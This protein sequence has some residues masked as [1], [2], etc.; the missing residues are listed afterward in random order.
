MDQIK[1]F[2]DSDVFISALLSHKGASFEILN[3]ISIYKII[4]KTI[5][6]EV[7]DVAKRLDISL[8]QVNIFQ[9]I[10]IISIKLDKTRIVRSYLS[11]VLDI[12]DSHVIAGAHSART[13]FLLTHNTKHYHQELIKKDLKIITMKPGNFLQYLRSH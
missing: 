12:E 2:L 3:N 4:T 7:V 11:Y 9:K 13:Q 10:K 1:V 5:Q 6:E 8:T